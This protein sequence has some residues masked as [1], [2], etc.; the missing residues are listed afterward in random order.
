MRQLIGIRSLSIDIFVKLPVGCLV[1]VLT[2]FVLSDA[3]FSGHC[4]FAHITFKA[5]HSAQS[6]PR[7]FHNMQSSCILM[8][9][10]ARGNTWR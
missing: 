8:W 1:F 7:G 5:H 2:K 10:K 9:I 4:D 6:E 3:I